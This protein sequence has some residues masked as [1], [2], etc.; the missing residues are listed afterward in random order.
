MRNERT[1][2]LLKWINKFSAALHS[3]CICF[4]TYT[5]K[6]DLGPFLLASAILSVMQLNDAFS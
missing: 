3:E 6:P 5:I 1:S 4:V 2:L